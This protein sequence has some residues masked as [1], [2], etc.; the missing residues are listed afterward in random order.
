MLYEVDDRGPVR[1]LTLDRPERKNAIPADGWRQLEG[2]FGEFEASDQRVLVITG[3]GGDFCSGAELGVEMGEDL[4]GSMGRYARVQEAGD[5]ARALHRLPKPTLAAV[6]GVAVGAGMNLALGCDLVVATT[7]ARF[8]ELFV[9]RGLTLDFGGTWLLPRVIGLQRAKELALTGRMVEA[10]E[11]L[12]IGLVLELVEPAQL[13][14]RAQQLAEE[15]AA[16]APIGQEF[17]KSAL[18]RSYQID[19][20][21][22]LTG[23]S[24]AQSIC[25]GTEDVVEGMSAFVEKRAPRFRGR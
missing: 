14:S 1:W 9:R 4:A 25:L 24:T 13:G 18:N 11:A 15:L 22:A 10:D 19:F 17:A 20:E 16:A 6:D 3:A 2:V 5:A 12:R 8:A 21:Q 7:R 23:E